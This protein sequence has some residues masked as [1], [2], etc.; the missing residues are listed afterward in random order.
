MLRRNSKY[1]A[2]WLQGLLSMLRKLRKS[3]GEV[4]PIIDQLCVKLKCQW[5]HAAH[6]VV[7]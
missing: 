1:S 2:M 5:G 7:G 4:R 3:Q 6:R